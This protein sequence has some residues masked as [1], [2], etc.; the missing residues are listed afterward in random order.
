M[1][2]PTPEAAEAFIAAHPE[3]EF[4]DG[5]F[6]DLCGIIRGKRYPI[7]D[8]HKILTKGITIPASV[9]LLSVTGSTHDPLGM[10]ISD[11][12]PDH[13]LVP[14][15][16]MLKPVLWA[17]RPLAQVYMTMQD[18]AGKPS[19]VDPRNVLRRV[20]ERFSDMGL[21]PVVA[22]EL[23]FYLIDKERTRFGAPRP[24]IS[25]RSK[26]RDTATQVYSITEL[27]AFA[28]LLADITGACDAQAIPYGAITTEY[29]P[30]QF[31]INLDH[32]PDPLLAADHA[33]LLKRAVKGCAR[34]HDLQAT[35]AP[36]P[37]PEESGSG[38][39]AH[40]SLIDR[41]GRNVLDNGANGPSDLLRHAIGG[42]LA[43]MPA[44]MALFAPN[45]NGFRRYRANNFVPVSRCWGIENRSAAVRV[46]MGDA[47]SRRIEHR[48]A[49]ADANP[50]LALA[51][52]LAA[53]HH[54]IV[55]EIDPGPPSTG[56]LGMEVDPEIPNRAYRALDVMQESAVLQD[57][58]GAD[59]VEA[60][61]TTKRA[62]MDEFYEQLSPTEYAWYLQAD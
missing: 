34:R 25:P 46:P 56:N 31:E 10:G 13:L 8:L 38:L 18:P 24:P 57:Y 12:D 15:E 11:G 28:G 29:A 36:K 41:E 58:F 1:L 3:I 42:C 19:W 43:M 37:Y 20:V 54:G 44:S 6:A 53:M 47:A 39:H 35:F 26:Q 62:E 21:T 16:G 49:G 40:V 55:K 33:V 27:E 50:Y 61:V 52:I 30:G 17:E 32:V 59:Y 60:Y 9:F 7:E 4:V 5:I 22:L 51:S 45:P 23:E 48:I 2:S 14:I